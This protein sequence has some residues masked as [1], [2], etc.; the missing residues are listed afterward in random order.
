MPA[1]PEL[2]PPYDDLPIVDA[3]HHL[4]DLDGPLRYPWLAHPEQNWLGDY[5]AIRRSYL[6]PEYRRDTALHNVVATVHV[7][8]ECDRSQQVEET[9]WLAETNRRH[10]MPHAIVAHAWV[11]EPNSDDILARHSACPLVRGIRTKPVTAASPRDSVRGQRRSLQDPA[12]VR[13]L[14]LLGKHGLSWD[15]RLPWWHLEE[16]AEVVRALPGLP[17]VLNHTGYPWNRD[18]ASLGGWRRGMA[19]LAAFPNVSCK[20][21]ALCVQGQPWTVEANSSIIL[22]TIA[23]FGAERCMFASNFPVD[24][25]KG[26]WDYIYSCFRRIVA[27]LPLPQ[28]RALF[29]GNAIRFYRLPEAP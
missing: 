29:A 4:W 26:S 9:L 12:W 8:A 25:L 17:I 18:E 20:I 3:H 13:G 6:P 5:S 10:G 14:E 11:D 16:A 24:G 7:E 22:E 27:H 1:R 15:L 23:L 28:Q 21:S 19:A 2:G